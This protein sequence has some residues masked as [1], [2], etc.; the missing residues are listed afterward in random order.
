MQRLQNAAQ[1][2]QQFD[3]FRFI[4]SCQT[5]CSSINFSSCNFDQMSVCYYLKD[6]KPCHVHKMQLLTLDFRICCSNFLLSRHISKTYQHHSFQIIGS[7]GLSYIETKSKSA[8]PKFSQVH[9]L[10]PKL[11]NHDTIIFSILLLTFAFLVT[12]RWIINFK[13]LQNSISPLHHS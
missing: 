4:K 11:S 8:A 2:L 1:T 7:N 9:W 10:H 6:Q 12:F 3:T 5:L 13:F